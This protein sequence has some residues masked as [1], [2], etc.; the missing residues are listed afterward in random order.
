MKRTSIFHLLFSPF[1]SPCYISIDTLGVA[2]K[3]QVSDES[4]TPH[5]SDAVD[6]VEREI[7]HRLSLENAEEA[8]KKDEE[9][10]GGK[11]DSP[12]VGVTVTVETTGSVKVILPDRSDKTPFFHELTFPHSSQV[13]T[14]VD[15]VV[16]VGNLK[17]SKFFFL[18]IFALSLRIVLKVFQF[19]HFMEGDGSVF[20][21]SFCKSF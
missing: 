7:E 12:P 17:V 10:E 5:I 3:Q 4:A 21:K 2:F 16:V 8:K 19:F 14:S 13:A 6:D 15:R 11:E 20:G 9:G 18:L 1:H